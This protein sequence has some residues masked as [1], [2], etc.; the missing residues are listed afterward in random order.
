[1]VGLV[2]ELFIDDVK[3]IVGKK[4]RTMNR[5]AKKFVTILGSVA[6]LGALLMVGGCGDDSSPATQSNKT[7]LSSA[8]AT[9]N[10]NGT[11]TTTAAVPAT[12]AN[13]ATAMTIP[14]GTVITAKDANGA[15]VN[16]T[17]L[18]A[19]NVTTPKSGVSGMPDPITKGF[20]I[21]STAG[22]V[23][24]T[25]GGQNAITFSQEVTINITVD[26]AKVTNKTVNMNKN[27]GKGWINVG[28][29]TINGNVATGKTDTLCWFGIDNVYRNTTG[30]T[31]SGSGSGSGTGF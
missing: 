11:V 6:M 4:E 9:V 28:T 1:L 5:N 17:S 18:P 30:S 25:I 10:T 29:A 8:N 3:T 13:G 23:D 24:I 31:G 27:D 20:T 2:Q 15:Q 7:Q 12:T 16:F 19:I 26:P 22:A 21:D 14:A